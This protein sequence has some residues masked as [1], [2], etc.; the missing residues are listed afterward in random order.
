MDVRRGGAMAA[1][2][3][4]AAAASSRGSSSSC[5]A[6]AASALSAAAR[7]PAS[8]RAASGF[9]GV[10]VSR[11][12]L[13]FPTP[14]E[15]RTG[16][17]AT[18]PRAALAFAYGSL[19]AYQAAMRTAVQEQL[20]LQLAEL[21]RRYYEGRHASPVV[22][23]AAGVG[24]YQAELMQARAKT[25]EGWRHEPHTGRGG[26]GRGRQSKRGGGRGAQ[27]STKRF[28]LD[29]TA[30][31]DDDDDD[32]EVEEDEEAGADEDE[33][34]APADMAEAARRASRRGEAREG[35][36]RKLFLKLNFVGG[37]EPGSAFGI[38]DLWLLALRAE[39]LTAPLF[40][41]AL[42]HGPSQADQIGTLEVRVVQPGPFP[43]RTGLHVLALHG[44]NAADLLEQLEMLSSLKLACG[45]APAEPPL[46]PTLL[47]PA[48]APPPPVRLG[49]VY[50][51]GAAP[52]NVEALLGMTLERFRLNA[53]QRTVLL[54]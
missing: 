54:R 8:S 44:P 21:A 34:T 31:L 30:E 10:G 48:S 16:P 24:L 43:V 26:G 28:A 15:L 32:D 4:L 29:E 38:D 39:E 5:T 23:R 45:H 2:T 51:G 49:L 20:N 7:G 3:A 52:P 50:K 11:G 33:F 42:W 36:E 6:P 25:E 17:P 12:P 41:R 14:E 22:Q 18:A 37:R 19:D 53:E 46:L 35:G 1:W 13:L 9:S 47:A 40:V 27:R